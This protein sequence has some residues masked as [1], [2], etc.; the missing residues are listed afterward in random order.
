[1]PVS[2]VLMLRRCGLGRLLYVVG[3]LAVNACGPVLASLVGSPVVLDLAPFIFGFVVL[4]F[5]VVYLGM[6]RA[7]R[8][9]FADEVRPG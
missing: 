6:S 8:E 7:V 9:Y 1:M 4:A 3:W 5:L 2:A